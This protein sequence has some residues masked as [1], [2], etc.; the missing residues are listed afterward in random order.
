MDTNRM[1]VVLIKCI[2][3]CF[4]FSTSASPGKFIRLGCQQL[5]PSEGVQASQGL[6]VHEWSGG[7]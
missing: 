4:T 5:L 1:D 7:I 2:Y 6:L 3:V